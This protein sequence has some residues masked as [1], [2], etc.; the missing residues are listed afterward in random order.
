MMKEQYIWYYNQAKSQLYSMSDEDIENF[1]QKKLA[2]VD[3]ARHV[4]RERTGKIE[5]LPP[6]DQS[7]LVEKTIKKLEKKEP[8]KA[9]KLASIDFDALLD[10]IE[11]EE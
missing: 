1:I 6:L 7:N 8:K 4:I 3:A 9:R 5:V 11:H 10:E 2:E